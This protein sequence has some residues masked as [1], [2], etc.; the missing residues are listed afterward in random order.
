MVFIKIYYICS[1]FLIIYNDLWFF[2]GFEFIYFG[3]Y[4]NFVNIGERCNVVG[5]RKFVRFI[6]DGDYE[7]S[8][9]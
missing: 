7:V 3:F 2:K 1:N 8:S 6:K 4:I 5:F 9:C